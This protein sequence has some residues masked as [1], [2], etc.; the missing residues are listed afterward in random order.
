MSRMI[1]VLLCYTVQDILNMTHE[2]ALREAR[3]NTAP[4]FFSEYALENVL[5]QDSYLCPGLTF[6][7]IRERNEVRSFHGSLFKLSYV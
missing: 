4:F 5:V 2:P 6:D 1:Q 3:S 7:F